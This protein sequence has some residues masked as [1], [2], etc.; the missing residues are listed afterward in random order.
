MPPAG[1][2][3][4]AEVGGGII[5]VTCGER[6]GQHMKGANHFGGNGS[7]STGW[8]PCTLALAGQ[9]SVHGFHACMVYWVQGALRGKCRQRES[10]TP[11]SP[12]WIFLFWSEFYGTV[13]GFGYL[14]NVDW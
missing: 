14:E 12:H 13:L 5:L 9:P 7:D 10:E 1:H 2:A 11:F 6:T 8:K 4:W 3:L